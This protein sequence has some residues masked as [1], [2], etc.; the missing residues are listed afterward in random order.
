[1]YPCTAATLPPWLVLDRGAAGRAV[2]A[3]RAGQHAPVSSD[4]ELQP[5]AHGVAAA[6]RVG[7]IEGS[8]G[9]VS[10]GPLAP[11]VGDRVM[12]AAAQVVARLS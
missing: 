6:W 2:L 11:G 9:V 8:V 7:A 5:D 4:G 1:V 12:A 3:A 10:L